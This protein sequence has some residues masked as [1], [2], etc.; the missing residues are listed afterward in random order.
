MNQNPITRL[1]H[2]LSGYALDAFLIEKDEDISYFLQDQAKSGALLVSSDEVVFFV[3][4]LDRDLYAH[5]QDVSLVF[6]SKNIDQHLFAYIEEKGLKTIGFDSEYT[7]Y[8]TA[9]KRMRSGLTFSPQSLVTEKLR[10][11][12]SPNEIQKMMRAAEIGSAGYDFVLAALRPGITEKE[13]VRLLHVFWANLG[14][15]KLSFPP[16]IAFGENAA[17]PHAI[18]TNRSLKKGDV[19]LID[20]GVCYE[21]YCSDMTRTVA[22]G[23]APEQQLLDG[24]LAVAEAQRRSI[25]LCREGVSCRAVHE[26]AVRVLREYGMEKAFIHGLGHG[27]GREVHEYPRLSLFSDAELQLNMAVTVEP[28]VYFPGV[29]GIRIEDT[30]VIGINENLNLTNRKVSPEII[31]I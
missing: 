1:Q 5:I 4:P 8:G 12:K 24:Y 27:V 22:F 23:E 26:E 30:I 20:I 6:C 29:G 18:P 28:G 9:Q 25:E 17:F 3:S 11:V 19:V 15:E 14:I 7:S 13:L 21:G 2:L 31:I 10:C 16:I